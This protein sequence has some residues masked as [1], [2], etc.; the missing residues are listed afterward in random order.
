VGATALFCHGDENSLFGLLQNARARGLSVP[1]Q[2]SIIAYD[3]DVSAH[4][5]PPIAA[6]AP[7]RRRIGA[8]TTRMLIDLIAEP[9][10][11]PPVQL[12]VEPR[13]IL[14]GSTAPPA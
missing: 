9:S 8:L 14:R 5:D 11:E 13:L 12:R 3:D 4:A 10:A 6:V 2:L 1:E 7:D